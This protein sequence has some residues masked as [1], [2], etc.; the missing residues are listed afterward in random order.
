MAFRTRQIIGAL[1]GLSLLLPGLSLAQTPA[2]ELPEPTVDL[3]AIIAADLE[4]RE[5]VAD[6]EAQNGTPLAYHARMGMEDENIVQDKIRQA[7]EDTAAGLCDNPETDSLE[8]CPFKL[9]ARSYG[10]I[11]VPRHA[12]PFQ[13]Q[14]VYS[15]WATEQPSYRAANTALQP[16][17]KRHICGGTLIAPDWVLTAAHC[18]KSPSPDVYGVRLDVGNIATDTSSVI[19]VKSYRIHPCYDASRTRNDVALLQLDTSGV[20]LSL[21][22]MEPNVDLMTAG[23]DMP[24][25]LEDVILFDRGAAL[26]Q[27]AD[28]RLAFL[29][30]KR[31]TRRAV[32]PV[33]GPERQIRTGRGFV[34][35]WAGKR[36]SL[37]TD[38]D[39]PADEAVH[40]EPIV[41]A[42]YNV[43]TGELVLVGSSG[44]ATVK[45]GRRPS[46]SLQLSAAPKAVSILPNHR[47]G[48][49]RQNS[50]YAVW[51]MRRNR[52]IVSFPAM[53][54]S[55]KEFP[56]LFEGKPKYVFREMAGT[57]VRGEAVFVQ[58]THTLINND[59]ALSVTDHDRGRVQA[60]GQTGLTHPRLSLSPNG[61]Y[62]VA[63][64][65]KRDGELG[66]G[67]GEIWDLKRSRAPKLFETDDGFTDATPQF[68]KDGKRFVLWNIE[69]LSQ[70][71]RLTD[72]DPAHTLNHSLLIRGGRL[73]AD[74]RINVIT[75]YGTAQ[76]WDATTGQPMARVYHG[77]KL[78]GTDLLGSV[79]L[80]WS[81]T[82]RIR[83]WNADTGRQDLHFILSDA[84]D[85]SS[86]GADGRTASAAK[87][88]LIDL[89]QSTRVAELPDRVTA[90]GWGKMKKPAGAPPSASLRMLS[91][92]PIDWDDCVDQMSDG[93]RRNTAAMRDENAFCVMGPRRKTCQGDSGGPVV[94]DGELVGIVSVGSGVCKADGKPS[95]YMTVA[96][97]RDWIQNHVCPTQLS[98]TASGSSRTGQ[99]VAAQPS[100]DYPEF[101]RGWT[102]PRQAAAL[103]CPDNSSF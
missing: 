60:V 83:V 92:S 66:R 57:V 62:L 49:E 24:G 100:G 12:A 103:S 56:L 20:S 27:F 5:P 86:I 9:P 102:P 6:A 98:D 34:L 70:V 73:D 64:G 1:T 65:L 77:G 85:V 75:E 78:A 25:M 40:A 69:G 61:R 58:D 59:G 21:E 74:G 94:G 15:D 28:G 53:S 72:D 51:D 42:D 54:E 18:L 30:L 55:S 29:D 2:T 37:I 7:A 91:L 19:P 80:T 8:K 39:R 32:D 17:E 41:A 93:T 63:F 45:N 48:V 87:V 52:Q 88:S 95:T 82:G 90:F 16:W 23:I 79:F 13:T 38:P 46:R 14:I 44:L 99:G 67:Y 33:T 47:L 22:P 50:S 81:R 71:W 43:E 96:R 10:S 36:Y 3:G 11:A 35:Q 76:V 31:G 68:T 84:G 97:Y 89:S 4:S 101:C 26:L